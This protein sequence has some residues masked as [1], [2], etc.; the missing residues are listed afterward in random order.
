[1]AMNGGGLR[2]GILNLSLQ[3]VD[4]LYACYMPFLKNGGLFIVTRKQFSLGDDVFVL[5]DLMK[6]PD[7]IPLTGKI[8]W[9]SPAG[10]SGHR[11]QGVG[12][13]FPAENGEVLTTKIETY[14]AGM[15]SS[16]KMTYTL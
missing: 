14:I 10:S 9:I 13:E 15:L 7:K 4:E 11:R 12:I 6:E 5:L 16:D 8:V 2:S 1:M 3:D